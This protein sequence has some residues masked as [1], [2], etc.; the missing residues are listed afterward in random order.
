MDSLN[1]IC[2]ECKQTI[3]YPLWISDSGYCSECNLHGISW[4][5][6]IHADY[7]PATNK[8]FATL[9]LG[10]QRLENTTGLPLAHQAMLEEM[11]LCW[12]H[13]DDEEFPRMLIWYQEH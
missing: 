11:L 13:L 2:N 7:S 12:T 5:P 3:R 8:L 6:S 9:F 1:S 10:I 4:K